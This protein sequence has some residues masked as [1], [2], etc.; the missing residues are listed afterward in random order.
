MIDTRETLT[1]IAGRNASDIFILSDRPLT[2]KANGA[3]RNLN[4]IKLLPDDTRDFIESI[5]QLA[6][7]RDMD[8]LF[9]RGDDCFSFTL[10]PVARF[11]VSAY[12]QRGTLSAA[13]RVIAL[14]CPDAD[15][16]LI[17]EDVRSLATISSGLILV[18]GP[19]GSGRTTTLA[20]LIDQIN[21][22]QAKHIIT[23]EDPIEYLHPQKQSIVSQRELRT[24]TKS[25]VAALE[26]ALRQSPDV[27][28]IDPFAELSLVDLAL[29]A[30]E[31]GRLILAPLH[32]SSAARAILS[33]VRLYPP[34]LQKQALSRLA[35]SL[36]AIVTQH[37]TVRGGTVAAEFQTLRVTDEVRANLRAGKLPM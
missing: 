32:Q 31:A 10:A 13:I 34:A 25:A 6:N 29:A 26:A 18:T 33:L 2:Y 3:L 35:L 28:L 21:T 7:D 14:S 22:A 5:Y 36:S 30:A 37:L 27:I 15:A 20:C 9:T 24:D 8:R 4:E 11:R 12:R 16:L 19:F 17:P 1:E 23:I